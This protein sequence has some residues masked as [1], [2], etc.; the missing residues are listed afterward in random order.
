MAKSKTKKDHKK[1]V[2]ARNKRIQ[3]DKARMQKA[4]R[5]FIMNLIKKEQEEGK[6]NNNPMINPIDGAIDGPMIEGPSI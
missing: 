4:Q 6:F 5:E 2:A 3:E 1:R